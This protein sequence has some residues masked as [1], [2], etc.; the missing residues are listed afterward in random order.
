[1]K[2]N[3]VVYRPYTFTVLYC[4][5]WACYPRIMVLLYCCICICN[6]LL[7]TDVA[8]NNLIKGCAITLVQSRFA[9]TLTLT[10]NPNPIFGESGF[11][12]SGRHHNNNTLSFP[13]RKYATFNLTLSH[14]DDFQNC[15]C[16]YETCE[17]LCFLQWRN[18][19]VAVASRD[20]GPHW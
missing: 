5:G 2:H 11:G 12:E 1:M 7:F 20:G 9:E 8:F 16:L 14:F 10:L 19:G 6:W 3:T 15:V 4:T 17:S 18:D 13:T